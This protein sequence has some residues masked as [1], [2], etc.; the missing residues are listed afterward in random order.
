MKYSIGG[1]LLRISKHLV[2]Y[3]KYQRRTPSQQL[4]PLITMSSVKKN[5]KPNPEIPTS[6]P[7]QAACTAKPTT[8]QSNRPKL[9]ACNQIRTIQSPALLTNYFPTNRV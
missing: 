3:K 8:T 9:A 1:I 2:C 4:C 7:R 6:R 5:L